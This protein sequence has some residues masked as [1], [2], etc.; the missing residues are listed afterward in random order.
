MVDVWPPK[1]ASFL[2]HR[3]S[4]ASDERSFRD[5]W[6][7]FADAP[8]Q[9]T[10]RP[11]SSSWTTEGRAGMRR[12]PV[13][14]V[15]LVIVGLSSLA[16]CGGGG[17]QNVASKSSTTTTTTGSSGG[18]QGQSGSGGSSGSNGSASA[19]SNGGGSTG[20][21]G[22]GSTGSAGGASTGSKNAANALVAKPVFTSAS[23]SPGAVYCS[24]KS[25]GTTV[26][27][28]WATKNA[29][30]VVDDAGRSQPLSGSFSF[31]GCTRNSVTLTA[32]GPGGS[33]S[34]TPSWSY[35]SAPPQ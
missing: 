14:A 25:T 24:S 21:N 6:L 23:A 30:S 35:L 34:A 9:L 12:G 32:R 20:S 15:A 16:A 17:S 5:P 10:D 27:I 33:T 3:D 11:I 2:W 18:G 28:S 1:T 29:T 4:R 22:G 31:V 8:R 19:G 13:A 7:P 26:T